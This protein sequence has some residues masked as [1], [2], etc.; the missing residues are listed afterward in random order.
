MIDITFDL[1]TCARCPNAAVMSI[2]A[3]VWNRH[4]N[5]SPFTEWHPDAEPRYKTF[6]AHIDLRGMFIDGFTFDNATAQ[7]WKQQ[8]SEAKAAVLANDSDDSPCVP[9]NTAIENFFDWIKDV[10]QEVSDEVCLWSQGTD[11]DVVILRNICYR[12]R[13]EVPVKYTNYRD[14]RT[15]FMEG[16]KTICDVA[17]SDFD[18]KDAYTLVDKYD[19]EGVQHSPLFD[20]RRSIFSTWQM[21]THLRCLGKS[22][23]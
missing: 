13:I 3:Q 14:H 4:A 19:G 10:S 8:S 12:Y 6:C 17:G 1:E 11:F 7:W 9:I 2:A 22:G 5:G 15:F 20:C 16:A 21:M 18:P 23:D